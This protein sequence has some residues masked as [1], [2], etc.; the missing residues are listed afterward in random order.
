LDYG[1]KAMSEEDI[2]PGMPG[3]KLMQKVQEDE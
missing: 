3:L 1:T 2:H